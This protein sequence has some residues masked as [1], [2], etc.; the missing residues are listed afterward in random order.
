[1]GYFGTHFKLLALSQTD[2]KY[3]IKNLINIQKTEYG[4]EIE[5]NLHENHAIR[6]FLDI[7][8]K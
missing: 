8:N 1:M 4:R 6:G 2:N 3:N 7:Y 5:G